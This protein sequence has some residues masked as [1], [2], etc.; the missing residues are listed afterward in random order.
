MINSETNTNG[1]FSGGVEIPAYKQDNDGI[2]FPSHDKQPPGAVKKTALRDVQN[3]TGGLTQKHQENISFLSGGANPDAV[4]VCGNK[5]LTPERPSPF[6]PTLTNSCAN[7]HIINARRRFELELGRGRIQSN[8]NKVTGSPQSRQLHLLQQE[9]PQ[10]QTQL[11]VTNN[12][13]VPAATS[14]NI[15]SVNSSFSGLSAPNVSGKY[16]TGMQTTQSDSLKVTLECPN[17]VNCKGYDDQ[18]TT[19]RYIRLQKFLKEC[20]EPNSRNYIQVL[21]HLS[22]AELSRHAY[23]LEIRAYQ[24]A[25]EE[26]KEMHRMKALN[27]LGKSTLANNSLQTTSALADNSQ[28]TTSTLPGISAQT[29]QLQPRK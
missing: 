2:G 13:C 8:V 26:V 16:A 9:T 1:V 28:Q 20:D 15:P 17:S 29:T 25:M 24:L 19:E 10:K 11:R 14:N 4:K 22:P 5:R 7:E 12:Y 23:E 6:Y 21:Q 3:Q 27:I 18:Q